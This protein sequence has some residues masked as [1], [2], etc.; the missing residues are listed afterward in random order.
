MK[1]T[2]DPLT[3]EN[4]IIS[5]T[6]KTHNSKIDMVKNYGIS[7]V[8]RTFK[9]FKI[10]QLMKKVLEENQITYIPPNKEDTI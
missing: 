6:H 2:T 10:H 1:D 4:Q 5:I 9:A 3:Q 8:Q 7:P